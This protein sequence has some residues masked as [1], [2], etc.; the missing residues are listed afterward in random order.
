MDFFAGVILL[1][2]KVEIKRWP[3][4]TVGF[5]PATSCSTSGPTGGLAGAQHLPGMALTRSVSGLTPTSEAR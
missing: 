3:V 2:Q 4:E 1:A 5:E